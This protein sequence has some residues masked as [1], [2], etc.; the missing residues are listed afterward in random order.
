MGVNREMQQEVMGLM[1]HDNI[2]VVFEYPLSNRG[3]F[4]PGLDAI[5]AR[6]PPPS[7]CLL[8]T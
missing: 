1:F 6:V 4:Y 2:T 7:V 3:I 5:N 8:C